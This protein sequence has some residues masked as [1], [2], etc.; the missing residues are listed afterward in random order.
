MSRLR[1]ILSLAAI[2]TA[3]WVAAMLSGQ[4]VV[5]A[6]G[7]PASSAVLNGLVV[8][9]LLVLGVRTVQYPWSVT[10]SFTTYGILSIP[11]LLLGP[12]GIHKPF[13]A[14][15]AGVGTDLVLMATRRHM[16]H[17][18]YVLAFAFWGLLLAGL[19][20]MAYEVEAL[21]LPEK[22]KF[23]AAFPALTV[24]FIAEAALASL[25]ASILFS[26]RR[27]DEHPSVKRLRAWVQK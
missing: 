23:V 25:V 15:V 22:E 13:V 5:L 20:R 17:A 3:T 14:L 26:K 18:A 10:I 4:L 8:P 19:A 16:K 24:I 2:G 21:H 27:L 11:F 9:F 7:V 6:S 1:V 12:P